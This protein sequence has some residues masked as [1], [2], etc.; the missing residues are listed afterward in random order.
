MTGEV[1]SHATRGQEARFGSLA[2]E[3]GLA[4]QIQTTTKRRER[5]A[6]MERVTKARERG[7]LVLRL[8]VGWVFLFAGLEKVF[9]LGG[10]GPFDASGF[11]KFGTAGTWPG[12]A[13]GVVANPTQSFWVGLAADPTVMTVINFVVPFGQIAIGAALILGLF[14]RFA[15]L[16]GVVMM[17]GFGIA[18]WDF[19]HGIV[20]QHVV[21]AILSGILGYTAAGEIYGLD[22]KVEESE[23][24]HRAPALRYVL[25]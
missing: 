9:Q 5:G 12:V 18:A 7:L 25:G 20:N 14:T 19:G 22:A 10:G 21:Y 4:C 23:L 1:R 6:V 2:T 17:V 11:L 16:M 8:V 3:Y 15:S 13:E 24:V